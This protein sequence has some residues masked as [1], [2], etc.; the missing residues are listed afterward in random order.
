MLQTYRALSELFQVY[1]IQE[2]DIVIHYNTFTV[3]SVGINVHINQ[4]I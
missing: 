2:V 1:P 4:M 3:N